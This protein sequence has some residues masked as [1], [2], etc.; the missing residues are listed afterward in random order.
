LRQGRHIFKVRLWKGLWRRLAVPAEATLEQL[1]DAILKVYAFDHDHLYD[2]RY[3]NRLGIE[4]RLY[5]PSMDEGPWVS[6]VQVGALPLRPGQEM[7]FLYDYGDHWEFQITL[8]EIR[9]STAEAQIR[10]LEGEGQPP[11]QYP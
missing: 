5:H 11:E 2:F 9:P 7:T 6:E 8:E 10:L 4:E 1:A 3:E